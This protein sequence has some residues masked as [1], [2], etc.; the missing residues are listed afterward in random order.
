MEGRHGHIRRL[1]ADF[2][3]FARVFQRWLL[4][5]YWTIIERLFK[6][7]LTI[8]LLQCACSLTSGLLEKHRLSFERSEAVLWWLFLADWKSINGLYIDYSYKIIE[9][10]SSSNLSSMVWSVNGRLLIINIWLLAVYSKSIGGL[11]MDYPEMIIE[12]LFKDYYI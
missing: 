9:R 5:D 6:D 12:R 7:Y 1:S 4:D 3:R 2:W 11:S 8:I 10:L